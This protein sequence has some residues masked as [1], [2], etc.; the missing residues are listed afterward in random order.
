MENDRPAIQPG[1]G[2]N[3]PD[4][5]DFYRNQPVESMP[6]YSPDLD[7]DLEAAL[8]ER[9]ASSGTFLDLGTGPGTQA[10]QL[11]RRGFTVTGVDLAESAIEKATALSAEVRWLQDDILRTRVEE[12]FDF[13]FDR[14]CF[15]VLEPGDRPTYVSHLKR[16]VRP[17]GTV[18][19]KCFSVDQPMH[20]E[21]RGPKRFSHRDIE[22]IFGA[23]FE[24]ERIHDTVYQGTLE[25]FPKAL[26]VVMRRQSSSGL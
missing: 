10:I 26:F 17:G 1:P 3:F 6:W 16:L 19:L 22:D 21:G 7:A 24:I 12:V 8:R 2:G 5:Q 25:T 14:G 11:A 15:H 23:D 20:P 4:W 18:F 13:V 9:N